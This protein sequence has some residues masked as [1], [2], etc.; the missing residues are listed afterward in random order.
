MPGGPALTMASRLYCPHGAPIVVT[1]ANS[2]ALAD[3]LPLI[4]A[5]DGFQ[6]AG[7]PF[8]LPGPTPSPCVIVEWTVPPTRGKLK[9]GT[10]ITQTDVGLCKAATQAVQGP[11]RIEGAPSRLLVV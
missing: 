11:V 3:N 10:P 8:T 2:V 5:E 9:T 1:P 7:C 6:I 4:A